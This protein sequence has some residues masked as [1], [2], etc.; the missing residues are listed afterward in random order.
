[1][2]KYLIN[3]RMIF[4][5]LIILAVGCASMKDVKDF[6]EATRS[7]T[8]GANQLYDQ[9]VT[10]DQ[11]TASVSVDLKTSDSYRDIVGDALTRGSLDRKQIMATLLAYSISLQEMADFNDDK[12]I[13][14]SSKKLAKSLNSIA[15]VDIDQGVVASAITSIAK[16]YIDIKKKNEIRKAV[17]NAHPSVKKIIEELQKNIRID[18]QRLEIT[19]TTGRANREKLFEQLKVDYANANNADKALRQ[20]AASNLVKQDLKE[21]D[22]FILQILFLDQLEKT[23]ISCLKAHE[24]LTEEDAI[25]FVKEFVGNVRALTSALKV[26]K[27]FIVE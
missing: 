1:M 17:K 25:E 23:T 2:K 6:A 3:R 16:V 22:S 12:D 5:V 20:I 4:A 15:S 10:N 21:Q 7:M 27:P 18:K 19:K 8:I 13:E 14:G 9:I 24:K 11:N 26:L